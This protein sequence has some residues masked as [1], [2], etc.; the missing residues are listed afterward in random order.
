MAGIVLTHPIPGD[1]GPNGETELE[2]S[3]V[4]EPLGLPADLGYGFAQLRFNDAIGPAQRYT[5]VRKLGW[6]MHSSIWLARD[7]RCVL[8]PRLRV[9]RGE[10]E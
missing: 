7:A 4:S 10:F 5:I 9:A 1:V 3:F 2:Y 6:G 8:C